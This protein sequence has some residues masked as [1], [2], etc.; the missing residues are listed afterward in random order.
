[1]RHQ[2]PRALV[3]ARLLGQVGKQASEPI[4]RQRDELAVVG[5]PE[6]H[7]G[8]R[9][10]DELGVADPGRSARTP[11]LAQEV[12]HQHVNCREKGVE[13]GAH[14]ASLVDVAVATPDFGALRMLSSRNAAVPRNRSGGNSESII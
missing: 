14:E 9:Q 1:L 11:P 8:D 13:V 4:A 7:L 6:E 5:E 3:V 10:R 12:V 2:P